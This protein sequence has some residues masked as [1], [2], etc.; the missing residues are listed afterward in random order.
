MNE[1][2]EQ[3]NFLCSDKTKF[4]DFVYTPIEEA[5]LELKKRNDNKALDLYINKITKGKLP[6]GIIDSHVMVMFR[7]IATLNYEIRRFLI[8]A[9]VLDHL[10][11]LILEYTK[12]LFNNRNEWKFSLAK[13]PLSKGVNKKKEQILE[14]RTIIDVNSSNNKP[15]SEIKTKWGEL[16]T[17]FH[18]S[19]FKRDFPHLSNH[20]IDA[21]DWLHIF[22][23]NPKEYYK[24]FLSIFLK[25]GILFEN[26]MLNQEE[27]SFTKEVILPALLEI[28][29]ETGLKPLIV[30]LEPTDIE[31]D[32]FWLS[33]PHEESKNIDE[34]MGR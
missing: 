11:P 2:T 20:I 16:L 27:S 22:G 10:K 4:N 33:H 1:P 17:D 21:S 31:G 3:I 26:F 29:E 34:K 8:S 32:K 13:I 15:I 14:F 9:D 12:D 18:H 5:L 28:Q 25:Y 7:H 19:I 6:E 30:A 24:P 23:K